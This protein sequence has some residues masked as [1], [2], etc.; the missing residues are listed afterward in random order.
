MKFFTLFAQMFIYSIL[1]NQE[2]T[3]RPGNKN[4][5]IITL[6]PPPLA[7]DRLLQG[8]LSVNVKVC[9]CVCVCVCVYMESGKSSA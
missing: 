1:L 2:D 8:R 4:L 6:I 5:T 9:M 7:I 3:Q